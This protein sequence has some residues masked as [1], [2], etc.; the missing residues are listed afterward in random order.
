MEHFN[1]LCNVLKKFHGIQFNMAGNKF[2]GIDIKWDYT[3]RWCHI[4]MSGY[5]KNLLIKFKHPHLTK[6]HLSPHKCP[7]TSY[8]AKA[9]LT[10]DADTSELLDKHRKCRIQEIVGLLLYYTW[11]VDNKLLVAL[12]AIPAQQPCATI[13]TKQAVHHL[14]DHVAT[15]SS[16]VIIYQTSDMVLCAHLDAGFLNKTDSHSCAGAH[17][18]LSK[19]E[20]FPR[21]NGAVL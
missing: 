5:I 19:N 4:S 11:A 13:A 3:T 15:Y 18:F 12:S 16:N 6:P 1:H 8:G 21:F 10:P 14:L 17:I 7:P 2:A 9:H 20:P